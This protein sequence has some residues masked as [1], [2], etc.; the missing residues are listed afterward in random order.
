MYSSFFH[1]RKAKSISADWLEQPMRPIKLKSII[2]SVN[3]VLC[4]SMHAVSMFCRTWQGR[5]CILSFKTP[6][7]RITFWSPHIP[8]SHIGVLYMMLNF[9]GI[10]FCDMNIIHFFLLLFIFLSFWNNVLSL[11]GLYVLIHGQHTVITS[12]YFHLSWNGNSWGLPQW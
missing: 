7:C 8:T 6:R 5:S 1:N 12:I 11:L 10:Q 3:L 2:Q 4:S 9:K